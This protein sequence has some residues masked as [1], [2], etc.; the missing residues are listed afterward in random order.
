MRV[1]CQ[2]CG[3]AYNVELWRLKTT[4]FCSKRCAYLGNYKKRERAKIKALRGRVPENKLSPVMRKARDQFFDQRLQAQ[5]RGIGWELS[6]EQWWK[7]WTD[8]KHWRERG[9]GKGKYHMA[10]FGDKGPYSITNARITTIEENLAERDSMKW[11]G[12]YNGL[13]KLTE[14]QVREIR[15][16]EGRKSR[17]QIAEMFSINHWHVRDIQKRRCWKHVE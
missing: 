2:Y 17:A 16:L 3:D 9:R 6:F 1:E 15:A 7:L 10:R 14:K 13:S 4:K 5:H 8:S 12:E 11:S